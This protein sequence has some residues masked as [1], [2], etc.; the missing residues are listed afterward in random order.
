[1]AALYVA[2]GGFVIFLLLARPAAT[3]CG[4]SGARETPPS[5]LHVAMNGAAAAVALIAAVVGTPSLADAVRSLG[6]LTIPAAVGLA[7]AGW[8]AIVV[9]AELPGSFRSWTPPSHHEQELF[10]P[11]RHRRADVALTTA[12]VDSGHA[13]L[14][15]DHDP[16]TGQPLAQPAEA[17]DVGH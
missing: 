14:W 4:C 9:V 6:A 16:S 3:S 13:S 10:D 8:L 11:D 5:W 7:V 12:G 1:M 2:F 17:I 15:P